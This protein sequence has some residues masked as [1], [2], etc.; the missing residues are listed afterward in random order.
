MVKGQEFHTIIQNIFNDVNGYLQSSQLQVNCPLCQE[1]EGLSFPDGKF[2]LEINTAKRVFRCWKCDEPKFSGSLGKLIRIFGS[3]PDYEVYKS[4]ADSL[5][6]E[7]DSDEDDDQTFVELPSEMILFS[8]MDISNLEHIEA[9]NYMLLD[10]KISRDL[11]IKYRVGFC[12]MG[13]YSKRIIIPSYDDFGLVNYFVARKYDLYNKKKPP[14][15]NPKSNKDSIIF[16]EGYVN[17]DSTIYIVEGVFEMFSLPMNGI[18]LLGKSLSTSLFFKLKDIKPNIIIILDPDA[19]KN[20]IELFYQLN[21]IYV[22]CEER[23]K[24]VKLPHK[25]DDLDLIRR[26][27]GNDEVIN[28][29]KSARSLNVDDHFSRF[30][31]NHYDKKRYKSYSKYFR[32]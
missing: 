3:R 22:G 28:S 5:T 31:E 13:K 30:L 19:Y 9:Y 17:W 7:Y 4:Y 12:L 21:S 18:P 15:D 1:K 24:I 26:K 14:Y 27:H 23:V 29:L 32:G 16:N 8:D 2:N 20:S 10:R 6:Y 25:K 11:L